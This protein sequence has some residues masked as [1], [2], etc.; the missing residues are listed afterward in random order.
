MVRLGFCFLGALRFHA[1]PPHLGCEAA[2]YWAH[3]PL[4]TDTLKLG[5]CSWQTDRDMGW[6]LLA[7]LL[8]LHNL[9]REWPPLLGLGLPTCT[10]GWSPQGGGRPGLGSGVPGMWGDPVSTLSPALRAALPDSCSWEAHIGWK[11][12][13]RFRGGPQLAKGSGQRF[14]SPP[15]PTTPARNRSP[16]HCVPFPV[17]QPSQHPVG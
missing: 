17:T 15:P 12:R 7:P 16:A 9:G 6:K 5:S 14:P 3:S 11:K 13:L 4:G 10:A 1:C 8:S 2:V